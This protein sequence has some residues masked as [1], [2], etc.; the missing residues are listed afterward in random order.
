MAYGLFQVAAPTARRGRVALEPIY[1]ALN[2]VALLNLVD[3][4]PALNGW[5]RRT[6]AAMTPA[7]RHTNRLIFEGIS[8][9]LVTGVAE[10][11]FAAYLDALTTRHPEALRD[12]V[13]AQL[14]GGSEEAPAALLADQQ[15]Y[16]AQV[17]RVSAGAPLDE[18][19]HNE[20]HALLNDPFRMHDLIITHLRT[21]WETGLAAEWA[22]TQ[23]QL[24]H[25]VL[26][27][28]NSIPGSGLAPEQI[29]ER[30]Q[31]FIGRPAGFDDT[32]ELVF[33]P[34]PH[35]GHYTTQLRLGTT[36]W[37]FFEAILNYWVLLRESPVGEAELI[38][39]LNAL[40]EP[41]RLRILAL[42]AQH[43]ELTPQ[44]I[45]EQLGQSQPNVSRYLKSLSMYVHERRGKDGKKHYRLSPAQLDVTFHGLKQTVLA[46][47]Q[48][49]AEPLLERGASSHEGVGRWLNPQGVVN[50][51]P[52]RDRDRLAV[53]E[54]VAERFVP[55]QEYTEKEVNAL[56]TQ[57]VRPH[58]RDHVTIR[59]DLIDYQFLGRTSDGSRY[60][61]N[62]QNVE[63]PPQT[64][65]EPGAEP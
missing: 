22:R 63:Q 57:Y 21:L 26:L 28:Q 1:N 55:G 44:E 15:A 16:I 25:S 20:V 59:R 13:L 14:T 52:G 41:M 18:A 53:L 60:W 65:S 35:T 24:Q 34:S 39:R 31:T 4:L 27:L 17:K 40:T 9:A 19:L 6:A 61:R 58:T 8:A 32:Q 37:L 45:M 62:T 30:L 10:A 42:L 50:A 2:S 64:S 5:V 54:Y 48:R 3:T 38:G 23:R 36:R 33:V 7:E 29:M 11:D 47:G 43:Y 46:A 51:W 56:I 12:Q 49:P